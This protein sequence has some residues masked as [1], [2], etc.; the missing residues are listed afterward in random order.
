MLGGSSLQLFLG[1]IADSFGRR[2]SML[3]GVLIFIIATLSLAFSHSIHQFMIER[4]FQG[5]GICFIGAVGY[6]TL[7]DIFNDTDAV[8]LTAIMANLSI[9]APL[10]GPLLGAFIIYHGSWRLIF[11]II[12]GLSLFSYWGLWKYM[13]EPLGLTNTD[14]IKIEAQ[15]FK[16]SNIFQNYLSLFRSKNFMTMLGMYGL[17]GI[18]CMIWIALSPVMIISSAKNSLLIYGLWQIPMFSAFIFAN[19]LLQ[20]WIEKVGLDTILKGGVFCVVVALGLS[21]LGLYTYGSNFKSLVPFFVLYFFGY[22]SASAP[23]YRKLFSMTGISK[24]T[25]GAMISLGTMLIQ[26]LG[27]EIGNNLFAGN[28]YHHLVIL[29]IV[30]SLGIGLC[31]YLLTNR[32]PKVQSMISS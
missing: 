26:S 19:T 18:P 7:Q 22:A 11:T 29:F 3:T 21:W 24:G 8:K 10:I 17:M 9:I 2:K 13:P 32:T 23:I 1:P 28:N 30:L 14:G 20:K 16:L 27:I 4:F 15:P 6:A 25:T 31:F 5:M 12:G